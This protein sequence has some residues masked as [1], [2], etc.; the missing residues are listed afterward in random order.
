MSAADPPLKTTA[1]CRVSL[2]FRPVAILSNVGRYAELA[3][4]PNPRKDTSPFIFPPTL[5]L[6]IN[7][8][9]TTATYHRRCWANPP[10]GAVMSY[11]SRRNPD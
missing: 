3:L 4:E 7:F 6:P 10:P 9:G 5:Q 2:A 8:A 11:A 1:R